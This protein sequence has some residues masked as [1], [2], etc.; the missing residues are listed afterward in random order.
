MA[1]TILER[2]HEAEPPKCPQLSRSPNEEYYSVKQPSLLEPST[3]D[4]WGRNIAGSSL[5]VVIG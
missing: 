3:Q 5:S 4:A 2:R 1:M